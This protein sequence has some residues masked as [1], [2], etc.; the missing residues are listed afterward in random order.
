MCAQVRESSSVC[1]RPRP[2]TCLLHQRPENSR[3]ADSTLL[4]AL[5][6]RAAVFC[7]FCLYVGWVMKSVCMLKRATKEQHILSALLF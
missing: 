2:L 1:A 5:T 6:S 3:G 4:T 7:Y